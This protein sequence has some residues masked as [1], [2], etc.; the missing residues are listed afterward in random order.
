M[1]KINNQQ[2]G[3]EKRQTIG[4]RIRGKTYEQLYGVERAK[5]RKEKYS[6]LRKGHIVSA[7]TRA[8]ITKGLTGKTIS[9]ESIKKRTATR[10]KL[11]LEGKLKT[12][13]GFKFSEESRKKLSIAMS[14]RRLSEEHKRRIGLNTKKHRMYQIFPTKDTSIELK[15][16]GFLKQLN[17][18]FYTHQYQKEIEHGYQCDIY[19]PS[20]NL[21]LE[22]DGN[23]WHGNPSMY[24]WDDLADW[25]KD[26]RWT[27]DLRTM[28]LKHAGYEVLRL[29]E[30]DIKLMTL[31]DFKEILFCLIEKNKINQNCKEDN[32]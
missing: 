17:I 18:E 26:Q 12:N 22:A 27:D 15:L 9:P 5:I 1:E 16:Q 13:K 30:A 3:I 20:M 23:Y 29:W 24:K 2:I 10:R 4:D 7:V 32:K 11:F 14:K 21:I 31:E 8:K 6:A 28:E 25:Q 19:I